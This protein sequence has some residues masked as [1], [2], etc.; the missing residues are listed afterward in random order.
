MIAHI[1]KH[2][3]HKAVFMAETSGYNPAQAVEMWVTYLDHFPYSN[4]TVQTL[5]NL[6]YSYAELITLFQESIRRNEPIT[7][8]ELI[9]RTGY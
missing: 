1:I 6:G 9:E 4:I 3:Y 8:R 2:I 5:L 7:I